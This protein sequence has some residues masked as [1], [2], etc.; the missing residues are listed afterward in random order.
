MSAFNPWGRPAFSATVALGLSAF[1][2]ILVEHPI[3]PLTHDE[4]RQRAETVFDRVVQKLT[5]G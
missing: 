5:V 1:N 4:V 2:V 3:Q